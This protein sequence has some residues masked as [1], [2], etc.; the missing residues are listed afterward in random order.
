MYHR[1]LLC[2]S[3]GKHFRLVLYI[4]MASLQSLGNC[5]TEIVLQV[6]YLFTVQHLPMVTNLVSE[7]QNMHVQCAFL[8]CLLLNDFRL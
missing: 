2:S 1:G 5:L 6:V 3:N 8:I 4:K 7:V